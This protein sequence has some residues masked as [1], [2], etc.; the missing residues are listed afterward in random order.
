MKTTSKWGRP[1]NEDDLKIK[2]DLKNYDNL[3]NEDIKH[4]DIKNEDY[5]TNENN[6]AI[7]KIKTTSKINMAWKL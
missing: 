7:S 2:N 4:E 3:K 1:Q 6:I 5:I